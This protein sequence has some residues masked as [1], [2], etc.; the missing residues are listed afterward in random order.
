MQG[1]G[2]YLIFTS[3]VLFMPSYV[4]SNLS[5]TSDL[6]GMYNTWVK[7]CLM[8]EKPARLSQAKKE[9]EDKMSRMS[10]CK[11]REKDVWKFGERDEVTSTF[12]SPSFPL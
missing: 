1:S 6:V 2:E 10:K 11:G 12:L 9:M 5:Q 4:T 3:S 8:L 7:N